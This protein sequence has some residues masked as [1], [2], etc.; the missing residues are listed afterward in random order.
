M[1][2]IRRFL[3]LV[4]FGMA[5]LMAYNYYTMGFVLQAPAVTGPEPSGPQ[6]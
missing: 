5:G 2:F 3:F 6:N 1:G 4:V